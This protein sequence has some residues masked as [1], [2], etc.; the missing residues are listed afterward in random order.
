MLQKDVPFACSREYWN[1]FMS[2]DVMLRGYRFLF[3][4]LAPI[5]G[6]IAMAHLSDGGQGTEHNILGKLLSMALAYMFTTYFIFLA[7]QMLPG[8]RLLLGCPE[9]EG[10]LFR[11]MTERSMVDAW[12]NAGK[13]AKMRIATTQVLFPY[14]PIQSVSE[15]SAISGGQA[16]HMIANLGP[17]AW[18]GI[19]MMYAARMQCTSVHFTLDL[20]DYLMLIG[21]SGI[22]MIGIYELNQYDKGMKI[23]HYLGVAMA[24]CILVGSLIEGHCMGGTSLIVPT[25]LNVIAWS[26]FLVWHFK[27]STPEVA[28]S[29]EAKRE[30]GIN[31]GEWD[32]H[33]EKEL[34]KAI[35]KCSLQCVFLEGIAIY[36]VT[37]ALSWYLFQFRR[38]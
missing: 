32:D 25:T 9:E 7:F 2:V 14:R 13:W 5:G 18:V 22:M 26:C 35:N 21:V 23:G 37:L 17:T 4:A 3:Q 31:N 33:K 10:Y 20:V 19:T 27:Y 15:F 28:L 34:I 24:I 8:I 11:I 12:K 38:I 30:E 1:Q 6:L 16:N 36:C 29:F